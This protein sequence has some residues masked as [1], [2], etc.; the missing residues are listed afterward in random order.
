MGNVVALDQQ[1][2]RA[3]S[4]GMTTHGAVADAEMAQMQTQA[5]PIDWADEHA[6]LVT[7]FEE[8][9]D[10]TRDNSQKA[11]R[12]VDYY[13]GKQWT[14]DQARTLRKRGQAALMDNHIKPKIRFLQGL[15]QSKRTE[16]K[17]SP[18]TPNAEQDSNSCTDALRFVCDQNKF[19]KIRSKVFK[20]ILAAGW[21]GYEVTAEQR[22]GRENPVIII[23]RC[24][25][26]RM[27]WDPYS[28]ED[29]FE[30]CA[31]R[32]LVRWMDR[33]EAIA[34][35]GDQAGQVFDETVTFGNVG[36][37]FD[38]KPK[39]TAWI[40]RSNGR[41]RVRVVQL[42]YRH[43]ETD[44]ICFA[45][46]TRG[47]LLNY[48]PSPWLDE[49]GQPED[50]Y[51]WGSANVDRDNNRYGEIRQLIDL[52]DGINHRTSKFQH[53]I[54]TRQTFRTETA[55]GSMSALELR[56][57]LARPDGDIVL[58][59]GI[60]FGKQFGIIP[61]MDM[62]ERQ[63]E[64]LQ[65]HEQRFASSGPNV[66]MMGKGSNDQSGR[67]ILANQQGGS[68]EAQPVF[69][70]LHEMDLQLYRKVW[71]RIR[72]FWT[73]EQWVRVT[74][75]MQN[76]RWVGLNVP[77]QDEMGNPVIDPQTGQPK[78]QNQLSQLD[79]DIELDEAPSMGTMQDEEFGKMT[80][81]AKVVPSLQ[82]LPAQAWLEMSNLRSK[83]K[84]S[85]IIQQ[86]QQPSPEQ[87]QAK[88]I[89]LQGEAAKVQETQ[90]KVALN[91]AN[92]R[93]KG[94]GSDGQPSLPPEIQQA[95]AVAEIRDKNASA[96]HKTASAQ[97]TLADIGFSMADH[98]HRLRE[99]P[100][101][102]DQQRFDQQQG[103][104]AAQQRSQQTVE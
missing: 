93:E 21:G 74:D 31:H 101:W 64:L 25:W 55:L 14:E 90:S 61:T 26:D 62:A 65:Q 86:A 103:R 104:D 43:F 73:A 76:L 98:G 53:Q 33:S 1:A 96:V 4:Q 85:K 5:Q 49:Y 47:G 42:Y 58:A 20:D 9:E 24:P 11:E 68:M 80:E 45:E 27:G 17:A 92:A 100:S 91:L 48:G 94:M 28:A 70:T 81:L 52:Q 60:E 66:S 13:D 15:E 87:Q 16:P 99:N 22:P 84:I 46:F 37:M 56:R 59:P 51:A 32:F 8:S 95:Q 29:T 30:D 7:M 57:Q 72:Q 79:V 97:K 40:S 71:N 12:D 44:Q 38:D 41:W 6:R 3:A 34:E 75:D 18:R 2:R 89:A 83:G 10:A 78:M 88:A 50:P 36:G 82:Q 19:N 35:Y 63:F 54:S 69:D 23:R 39:Q 102:Q 67:A 77:M